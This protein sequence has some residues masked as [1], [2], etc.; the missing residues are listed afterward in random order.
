MDD[1]QEDDGLL[2][3]PSTFRD[4]VS[5]VSIDGVR[6]W[7][8][9]LKPQGRFYNYR[10]ALSYIYLIVFFALPFIKKDD[11]PIFLLNIVE[12][13]FILFGQPIWPQDFYI[14][15]FGM[16][17]FLFFVVLFTIIYGRL[18]CGWVCPQTIFMEFVFR[19][20]EWWIDGTPQQQEKLHAQE[21]NFEKLRKRIL[22][23]VVFFILSYAIAHT[24][25]SYI[26]GV[27]KLIKIIHEPIGEHLALFTGLIVFTLLFFSVYYFIREIVCTTICP[28]GRLQGVMTDHNT[29]QVSYD[30]RR[31]EPRQR[32]SRHEPRQGDCVDCLKCVAVCPTGIDIRNG[33]Q[34]ECVGC[35]A[36]IDACDEI[37]TKFKFET[38]LIRYASK[39]NIE[40]GQKFQFTKRVKAYSFLLV[41][42]FVV[43]AALIYTRKPMVMNVN[44]VGG[45]L[46]QEVGQDSLSNY[47]HIKIINKK[48]YEAQV[49]ITLASLPGRIK[50]VSD[51]KMNLKPE[52]VSEYY[53]WV[54]TSK[55]AIKKRNTKIEIL[56]ND[57]RTGEII[58]E[59]KTNF[60]GPF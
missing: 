28:Y 10:T 1:N 48:N 25:L 34:L 51:R 35:T 52:S 17:T 30:Y 16:I 44:R 9:A 18:F 33:S 40:Q 47:Y 21:W 29:M 59:L 46:Y 3:R 11:D 60:Y 26:I 22:K 14:F 56:V 31:G 8:Y 45:Q 58:D 54:Y 55:T 7:I 36:C 5:T 37:M 32:Y 38:G 50:I 27:D 39:N 41:I 13:K 57:L 49:D 12:S 23:I 24:F 42:L 20:I 2:L 15:A 19:K 4:T 53:F 43:L 6:K